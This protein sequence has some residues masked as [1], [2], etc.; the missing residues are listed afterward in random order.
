MGCPVVHEKLIPEL[1][2]QIIHGFGSNIHSIYLT[3]SYARGDETNQSDI[4]VYCFFAS[5]S[6]QDLAKVGHIVKGI[7]AMYGVAELNLQCLTVDEYS[8]YGFQYFVSPL[9]Y[10]EGKLVYGALLV[11]E[12]QLGELVQFAERILA[13]AMMS[14][15][16]YMTVRESKEK[17][18]DGRLKRWVL[19]SICIALRI[20]NYLGHRFFPLSYT[21]LMDHVQSPEDKQV[22][23][24]TL[25]PAIL[26][27]DLYSDS[28]HVLSAISSSAQGLLARIRAQINKLGALY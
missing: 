2:K 17:L 4:D 20:E 11:Q 7:S 13:D 19:K 14:A 27:Q 25:D 18:A 10:F 6:A 16:H 23:S 15:R 26:K 8:Q 5:L 3:G 1:I 24:W 21:E 22:V 9:F 28:D 12:P